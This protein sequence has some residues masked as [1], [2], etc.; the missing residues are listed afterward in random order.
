MV[1]LRNGLS[2]LVTG[3]LITLEGLLKTVDSYSFHQ[4]PPHDFQPSPK[5]YRA[6]P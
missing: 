6:S 2:Q 3:L 1:R 5:E 4:S